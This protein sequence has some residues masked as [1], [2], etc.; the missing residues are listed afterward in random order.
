MTLAV[1][2]VWLHSETWVGL[3]QSDKED[4]IHLRAQIQITF[5]KDMKIFW[6]H[7]ELSK[8]HTETGT[9]LRQ[10]FAVLESGLSSLS[11]PPSV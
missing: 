2:L 3:A 9:I 6:H 8:R 7:C 5:Q 10:C 1:F 11:L 4:K